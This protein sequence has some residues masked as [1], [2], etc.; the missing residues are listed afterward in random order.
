MVAV[1]VSDPEVAVI[2]DVPLA[3]AVTRPE[4]FT[5]ATAASDEA[6]VTV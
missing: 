5:V 1:A 4:E 2:V 6:H 3:T